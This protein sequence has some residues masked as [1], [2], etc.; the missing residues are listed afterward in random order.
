MTV[1]E[2]EVGSW[3]WMEWVK[4]NLRAKWKI[5]EKWK[6]EC[7]IAAF[8]TLIPLIAF[9]AFPVLF[10]TFSLALLSFLIIY[11]LFSAPCYQTHSGNNS[12]RSSS[13]KK[14]PSKPPQLIIIAINWIECCRIKT[15]HITKRARIM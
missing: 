5:I 14:F 7:C 1:N 12:S 10:F 9:S 8:F 13:S 6:S 11:L 2:M 3:M 4:Y 15:S